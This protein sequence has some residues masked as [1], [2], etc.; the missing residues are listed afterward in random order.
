M[1]MFNSAEEAKRALDYASEKEPER[2]VS[3]VS[4]IVL[5]MFQ[6]LDKMKVILGHHHQVLQKFQSD[7]SAMMG[8]APV[9]A[10]VVS[11]AAPGASVPVGADGEPVTDPAQLE[12]EALMNAAAGPHPATAPQANPQSGRARRR[13]TTAVR[14]PASVVPMQQPGQ[15][16]QPRMGADGKLITDPAQLEAEAIMDAATE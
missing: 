15:Q 11:P 4:T 1:A 8:Q 7:L 2:W 10:P 14:G 5:S 9:D 6:Q 3:T 12:A 13:P 16:L